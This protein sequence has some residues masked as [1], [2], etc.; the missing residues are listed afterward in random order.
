[1]VLLFSDG[2]DDDVETLEQKS[3][4]LRK[5]GIECGGGGGKGYLLAF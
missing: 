4:D 1:M 2:L 5:E 3:D